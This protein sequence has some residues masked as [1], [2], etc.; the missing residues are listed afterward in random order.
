[1]ARYFFHLYNAN[2]KN[3]V[4]DSEGGVF[5]SLAEARS[6]AIALGR[7]IA[8]LGIDRST[9][10]VLV[11][12]ENGHEILVVPLA[13]VQARRFQSWIDL[14]RRIATYQPRFR[15]SIFTLL[16]TAA[17][18]A[19]I[20]QAIVLTH[21]REQSDST[22]HLAS[23]EAEASTLYVRFVPRTSIEDIESFMY[24][25]KASLVNGPLPGGWYRFRVSG[26]AISPEELRAIARIMAQERI[27]SLAFVGHGKDGR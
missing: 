1:M 24:A 6:E 12:D 18:L 10:Q 13:K 14:A 8:G 5:S 23:A 2:S 21:V 17:V 4:R 11:I 16:L 15:S 25:Y 26:A 20:G 27:V 9:W 22:Y 7:D 3:L 19:M